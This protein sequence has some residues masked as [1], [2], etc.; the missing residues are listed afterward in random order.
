MPD[1]GVG[2]GLAVFLIRARLDVVHA[3]AA[4]Q[5]GEVFTR[6]DGHTMATLREPRAQPDEWKIIARRADGGEK[7]AH[8]Q[9]SYAILIP[10]SAN[11]RRIRRFTFWACSMYAH[12][13]AGMN[14]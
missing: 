12:W 8:S 13:S 9:A 10:A 7:N 3:V 5:R 14:Q 2:D 4:D 11:A 6:R 1:V